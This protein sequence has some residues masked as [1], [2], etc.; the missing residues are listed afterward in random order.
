MMG[1]SYSQDNGPMMCFNSPKSWQLGWY[2]SRHAT[3]NFS[4]GVESY[5]LIGQVDLNN[6]NAEASD[7]VLIKLNT[8]SSTDY[9]MSFNRK[10]GVNSG[11]VEGGNQ[12]LIQSAGGEGTSYAESEL[13]AKLGSG[14][15]YTLSNFDG[16]GYDLT[17]TVN[18]INTGVSPGY[19][20]ITIGAGCSSN[21]ECDDGL[22]CNGLEVCDLGILTCFTD[23]G[24]VCKFLYTCFIFVAIF[25]LLP[26]LLVLTNCCYVAPIYIFSFSTSHTHK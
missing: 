22:A 7:R 17:V 3:Y 15:S 21:A 18:S 23:P 11:T 24:T 12:V 19:A 4:T 10:T 5:R 20:D 9:Y 25:C 2:S 14:G 6:G 13:L 8:G 1:F 16:S 26:L